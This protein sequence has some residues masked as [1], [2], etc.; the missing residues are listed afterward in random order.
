[1]FEQLVRDGEAKRQYEAEE[2]TC[3][4]DAKSGYIKVGEK[5]ESEEDQDNF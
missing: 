4:F 1:M 2:D 3:Y 5:V